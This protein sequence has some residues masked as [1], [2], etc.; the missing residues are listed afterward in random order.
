MYEIIST[1]T[2]VVSSISIIFFVF[3]IK[4]IRGEFGK[5]YTLILFGIATGVLIHSITEIMEAFNIIEH[6]TLML[7]MSIFVLTGSLLF[8]AAAIVALRAVR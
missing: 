1:G 4:N 5:S 2:L 3:V 8:I 6:E 7:L